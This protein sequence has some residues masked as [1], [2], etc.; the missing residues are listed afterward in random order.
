M[1]WQEEGEGAALPVDAD[2]LDLAAKQHRQL[3]ADGKTKASTAVLAG[4]AGISLLE[5]LENELLFFRRDADAGILDGEC[6]NL[7]PC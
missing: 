4:S 7:A 3:S 2:K 6:D 5:G 1:K